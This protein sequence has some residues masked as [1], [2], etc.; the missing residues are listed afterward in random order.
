MLK[1]SYL[2]GKMD[3]FADALE[4][5]KQADCVDVEAIQYVYDGYLRARDAVYS[6]EDNQSTHKLDSDLLDWLSPFTIGFE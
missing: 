4:L 3:G 6:C 2:T 5:L 1:L